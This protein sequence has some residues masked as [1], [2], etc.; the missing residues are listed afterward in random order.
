MKFFLFPNKPDYP[1]ITQT[2]AH[3]YIYAHT[4]NYFRNIQ[5]N[6]NYFFSYILLIL[7]FFI[8]CT[9]FIFHS[10]D[11]FYLSSKMNFSFLWFWLSFYLKECMVRFLFYLL[12]LRSQ[13]LSILLFYFR[14]YFV[15]CPQNSP[16]TTVYLFVFLPIV[17]FNACTKYK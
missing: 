12:F 1:T 3:A 15:F 11:C 7:F 8:S 5:R 14:L 9:I 6:E 10:I 17:F 16:S 13:L 2:R 4:K